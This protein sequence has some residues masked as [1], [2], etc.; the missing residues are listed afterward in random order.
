MRG[1]RTAASRP[2]RVRVRGA[3][4]AAFVVLAAMVPAAASAAGPQKVEA[5]LPYVCALPS[6]ERAST[7]RISAEF[8]DRAERGEAISP[9]GVTTTVE[10][11][12]EAVADLT[13]LEAATVRAATRLTVGVAQGEAAAEA[14]WHGTAQPAALPASGPL[15]LTAT[16]D[17]PTVTGQGHGE[18][19]FS[20]GNLTV[21]LTPGAADGTAVG[22][23]SLTVSC[24]PAGRTP[25]GGLLAT[26]PVGADAAEPSGS[27]SPPDAS[28]GTPEPSSGTP[29]DRQGDR[30]PE[31]AENPAGSAAGRDAPPCA[32]TEENPFGPLSMNA[33][34]TG[35][36][37]VKK[38]KG[39]SLLPVSCVLLETKEMLAEPDE[40]GNFVVTIKAEGELHH[41]GRKQS[42]PFRSTFL[43]FGFVPT[44]ATMVLEQ[45]G[46]MTI[47]FASTYVGLDIVA[48]TFVRVPL[49]L[50]VTDLEVNGVPLDVGSGCRTEKPLRSTDPDPANHPGDHLVMYG[51]GEQKYAEDATGYMLLTGGPLTGEATIPAFTGCGGGREDLDRLLTASVSGPGNHIKQIQG[52]TCT[53]SAPVFETPESRGQCT[54]DLQPYQIPVAER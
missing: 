28:P 45:T 22:P 6:G 48:E 53:P 8:P 36:S 54:E 14:I 51:K 26:V 42:P 43:S 39:A 37:N 18:L 25:E 11:P 10:L 34:I 38:Q 29:R 32:Y 15:T 33:Y 7:V 52:Q 30:A 20:A 17:V 21:D 49:R 1:N 46:P 23:R 19:R 50:R 47:E 27:P 2:S 16:G 5:E 12:A 31:V 13:A 3:A 4:I 35:Y 41:E 24:S 40:N 44:T 9:A